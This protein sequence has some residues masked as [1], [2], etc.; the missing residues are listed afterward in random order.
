MEIN[1]E[2]L[3]EEIRKRPYLWDKKHRDF[4]NKKSKLTAFQHIADFFGV[5]SK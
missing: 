1:I 4:I 2:C 3:I 5:D